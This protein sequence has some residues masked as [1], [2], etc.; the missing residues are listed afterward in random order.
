MSSNSSERSK[1]ASKSGTSLSI[2]FS[3]IFLF[4]SSNTMLGF[5]KLLLRNFSTFGNFISLRLS[6]SLSLKSSGSTSSSP[7]SSFLIFA[8][9]LASLFGTKTFEFSRKRDPAVR[10]SKHTTSVKMKM[11]FILYVVR[12]ALANKILLLSFNFLKYFVFLLVLWPFKYL[13]SAISLQ[14]TIS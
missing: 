7:F 5:G 1:I 11:M 12:I 14:S 8:C 4:L 6:I 2:L 9:R 13:L 10:S 3:S